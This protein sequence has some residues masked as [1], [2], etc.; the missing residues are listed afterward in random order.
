MILITHIG[1]CVKDIA[2]I[3][4][5]IVV[6][7]VIVARKIRRLKRD[8]ETQG[9]K[10]LGTWNFE[11]FQREKAQVLNKIRRDSRRIKKSGSL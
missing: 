11:I 10:G 4:I 7:V 5:N 9:T 1:A 3:V 8:L 6:V 2:F